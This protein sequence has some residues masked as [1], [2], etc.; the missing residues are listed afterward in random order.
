[1]KVKSIQKYAV[2]GDGYDR[3]SVMAEGHK[4]ARTIRKGVGVTVRLNSDTS[5]R[6]ITFDGE[7]TSFNFKGDE[8]QGSAVIYAKIELNFKAETPAV[9]MSFDAM[10]RLVEGTLGK[11][12]K[13]TGVPQQVVFDL[14]TRSFPI[15]SHK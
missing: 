7:I 11:R 3:L 5:P 2:G 9:T 8:D 13:V 6:P 15:R 10:K 1:M 14:E 12:V 4:T